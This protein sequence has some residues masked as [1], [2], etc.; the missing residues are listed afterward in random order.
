MCQPAFPYIQANVDDL[1]DLK[2]HEELERIVNAWLNGDD[3]SEGTTRGGSSSSN[4]Q[5]VVK[6]WSVVL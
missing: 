4:Q 1:Y 3:E 5:R 2:S 6:N